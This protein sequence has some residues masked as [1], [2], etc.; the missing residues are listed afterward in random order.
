MSS[1][2]FSG[3]I[4]GQPQELRG[5]V[6]RVGH[7]ARVRMAV[8][9]S[10]DLIAA[11]RVEKMQDRERGPAGGIH[12]A[13]AMPECAAG[14]GGD[15][16]SGGLRLAVK[17][18]QA[19]DGKLRERLGIDFRSAFRSGVDAVGDLSSVAF[20]AARAGVEKERSDRRTTDV[21]ADDKG[22]GR[23]AHGDFPL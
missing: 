7:A 21:D 19:V 5:P 14:H 16:E 3:A 20:H 4:R 6:A 18:V 1:T 13:K 8:W 15:P 10:R 9:Y 2:K 22:I 12:A 17:L 11:A 23:G